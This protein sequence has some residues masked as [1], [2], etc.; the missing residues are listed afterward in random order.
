MRPNAALPLAVLPL[1]GLGVLASGAPAPHAASAGS[2]YADLAW[3]LVGPM[4]GGRTRAVAGVPGQS[5]VFYIGAVNGGVWK[6]RDAGRTWQPIFD[7][8]PTQSI[9]AIAVAPSDPNIVYVA[10]GEGLRRP[11]LSVGNGVYRSADAGSTWTRG[12]LPDGQ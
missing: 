9:G 7:A 5:N 8:E 11:D 3:R 2:V 4:R 12:G 6:T 10:S 1:L